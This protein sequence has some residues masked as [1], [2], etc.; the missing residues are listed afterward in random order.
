MNPIG[1]ATVRDAAPELAL[2]ILDGA[3]RA[4]LLLHVAGC[5]RCQTYV[6][7]LSGV[8]DGLARLA[9][10]VEPPAGF[11]R[12]VDAAIRGGRRR[13]RRWGTAAMAAAA[14]AILAIVVVRVV[15]AGSSSSPV[16]A[17]AIRTGAMIGANNIHVGRV[18]VSGSAPASLAVNVDYSLPDGTYRLELDSPGGADRRV[19]TI[20]VTGGHGQWT[21][22]VSL[23]TQ[24]GATLDMLSTGDAVVCQAAV[25]PAAC[26]AQGLSRSSKKAST[27]SSASRVG[28]P[29]SS[30][31]SRV[32]TEW[33]RRLIP[34]GLPFDE[35]ISTAMNP[36]P[37]SRR[38]V[39]NR[40]A[41]TAASSVNRNPRRHAPP[42]TRSLTRARSASSMPS[43]ALRLRPPGNGSDGWLKTGACIR[44]STIIPSA[45]PPVKHIPTAPTP[46]PPQAAWASAANA[47]SQRMIGLV[48]FNAH[49]VN[50]RATQPP[51][52]DRIVYPTPNGLPGVPNSDGIRT[53]KP[54]STTRRPKSITP[55]CNPGISWI[56][57][58]AGPV[59]AEYT[60]RSSPSC[61]NT[62][63]VKPASACG[64][65][66]TRALR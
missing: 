2:G 13:L 52:S 61:S 12:R 5:P 3:E 47:R 4:E 40:A 17:P 56:T 8:A 22:R 27:R 23:P 64:R 55:G 15:D 21:G 10:E 39:S 41:G 57:I 59:P 38:N 31:K 7:E 26:P 37:S 58:T 24:A 36:S 44:S 62:E 43:A 35:S 16:A 53:W 25:P 30:T 28:C 6:S 48:S 51:T 14:A 60:T 66:R 50:S 54:R 46:G 18:A 1:C 42:A 19:G 49:V 32:S 65:P 45:N 20:T 9:P 63:R 34:H 33:A 11:S 29:G